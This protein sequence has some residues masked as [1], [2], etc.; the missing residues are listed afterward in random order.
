[1]KLMKEHGTWYVPTIIA[2]RYVAEKAAVPGYYPPQI[3]AKARQVGPVIQGTAGRAYRAGVKIAFG[4]DAAVYPHGQNAKEFAYMVEAG[5]P[6]AY[7]LQA[8]TTHAAELLKQGKDLGS[9]EAGKFA[10]IVAVAG[11][12]LEDITV[13]QKVGFVMKAGQVWRRADREVAP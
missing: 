3:A 8:A 6:P 1:M 4:T 11:N 2:G 13:M 12:P 7:T 10:D 9:L 5:M